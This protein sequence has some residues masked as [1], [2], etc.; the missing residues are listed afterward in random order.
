M[1]AEPA[2]NLNAERS[3]DRYD[4]DPRAWVRV[5]RCLASAPPPRLEIVGVY[6]S[7]PDHPARPSRTD[8][9]RAWPDL[10]YLIVAVEKGRSA[11][12]TAW[13]LC[14]SP[15]GFDEMEVFLPEGGGR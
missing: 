11:A 6:H 9:E 3:H 14:E 13:V 1:R 5:E 4:L 15:R 2:E 10:V 7:H 8:L 12:A